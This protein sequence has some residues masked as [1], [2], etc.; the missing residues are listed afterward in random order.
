MYLNPGKFGFLRLIIIY[1][2]STT[3]TPTAAY[4]LIAIALLLSIASVIALFRSLRSAP[5]IAFVTLI[6][7]TATASIHAERFLF[8]GSAALIALALLYLIPASVAHARVGVPYIVG[9][10]LVGIAIGAAISL[11]PAAFIIGA[12]AGTLGGGL[13]FAQTP[14]GHL[15]RFP[16]RQFFNS[17]CAKGLPAIVTINVIA[18]SLISMLSI[19]PHTN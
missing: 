7:A 14:A 19:L 18:I 15:L 1:S 10:A 16:S 6:L 9:G 8:W 4:T 12:A 13:A 17:L 5:A 2:F 3:M 11:S